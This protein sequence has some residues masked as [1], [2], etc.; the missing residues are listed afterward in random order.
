V[1]IELVPASEPDRAVLRRLL[2]LYRYD[3]SEFNGADVD[4]HGEFGYRYLDHYWTEEDRAAFLLQVDGHWA[5][6]ALVRRTA[7]FDM[8]EFFV[9][10]K[11]RRRGIGR[12]AAIQLFQRFPGP[13]QVRQQQANP[14]S[15][16]FWRSVIPY[17]F[18]E[19]RTSEEVVQEFD[20]AP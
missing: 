8:A 15:T 16:S 4:Q 20:S 18:K 9:M 12:Q 10:R 7:P 11:Y 14:P 17:P 1:E 3:V 6:F 5:G 19:R 2:E 13:W